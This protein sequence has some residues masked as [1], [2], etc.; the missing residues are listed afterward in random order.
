LTKEKIDIALLQSPGLTKRFKTLYNE[1]VLILTE[2]L[3]IKIFPSYKEILLH[4]NKIF[5]SYWLKS[6][7]FQ[8]PNTTVFYHESEAISYL[9]KCAMPIVLKTSIGASGRGVKIITQRRAAIKYV[10]NSFSNKGVKRNLRPNLRMGNFLNRLLNYISNPKSVGLKL[11]KIKYINSDPEYGYV[12]AQEFI[13]HDYEWRCVRIGDSFFAHKKTVLKGKAS[14]SLRK[15]YINPPLK[16][17]DFVKNITDSGNFKSVA[18][19]IFEPVRD[20]FLINEI[21]CFFGQSDPYQMLVDNTPGRYVCK[22]GFWNFESG[23]FTQNSCYNLR[24]EFI[25][26]QISKNN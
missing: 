7:N 16:L 4:E 23:D 22:N 8:H 5:L 15:E 10:K 13:P 1:R 19:D 9:E 25:L 18:I 3:G 14:G 17:L 2:E 24:M 11:S 20:T 6:G 12:F 21:Q 26:Q